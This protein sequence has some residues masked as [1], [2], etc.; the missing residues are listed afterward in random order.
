[1]GPFDVNPNW[2]EKH[3]YSPVPSKPIWR[4]PAVF[5]TVAAVMVAVVY[6]QTA[7]NLPSRGVS[8]PFAP[9]RMVTHFSGAVSK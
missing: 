8:P 3:W 7:P 2:F 4:L 9:P 6:L 5:A 1:M